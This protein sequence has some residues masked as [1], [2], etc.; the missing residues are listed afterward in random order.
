M[1]AAEAVGVL[2][3]DDELSSWEGNIALLF[4]DDDDDDED[5]EVLAVD[6]DDE[7]LPISFESDERLRLVLGGCRRMGTATVLAAA[8]AAADGPRDSASVDEPAALLRREGLRCWLGRLLPLTA[9]VARD[10]TR[11]FFWRCCLSHAL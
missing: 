3:D 4:D 9:A 8:W 5:A 6:E 7:S 10:R 2:D 11:A 1:D